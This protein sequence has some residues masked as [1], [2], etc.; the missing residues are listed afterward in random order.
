MPAKNRVLFTIQN[1]V[2]QLSS[3]LSTSI[4]FCE[5]AA[6]ETE[7]LTEVVPMAFTEV[8]EAVFEA[9]ALAA[10]ATVAPI[11]VAA[12]TGTSASVLTTAGLEGIFVLLRFRLPETGLDFCSFSDLFNC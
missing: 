3:T 8:F 12:E 4:F 5:M 9:A 2:D 1:S 7:V 11:L 6:A 10:E